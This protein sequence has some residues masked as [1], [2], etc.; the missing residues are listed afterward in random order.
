MNKE[1]MLELIESIKEGGAIVRGKIKPRR[2]FKFREPD[3]R[4][5]RSKLQPLLFGSAG[6]LFFRP[7]HTRLRCTAR[8]QGRDG[9]LAPP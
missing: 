3:V 6:I 8:R 4:A 7:G 5:I 1:L 2:S 9:A